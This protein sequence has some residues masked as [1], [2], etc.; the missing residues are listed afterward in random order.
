M[1]ITKCNEIILPILK[2]NEKKDSLSNVQNIYLL[3]WNLLLL[4]SS[5]DFFSSTLQQL[6]VTHFTSNQSLCGLC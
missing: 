3:E 6:Q 2:Q 4:V 5:L 1:D